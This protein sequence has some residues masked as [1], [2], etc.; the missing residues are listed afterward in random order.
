[1]SVVGVD[2]GYQNSVI[3]VAGR[4]GVDVVMNGSAKRL[5]PYVSRERSR[6]VPLD[7]L[8]LLCFSPS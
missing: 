4:G 8:S 7:L 1:M 6:A 2:L 3:A 5:N